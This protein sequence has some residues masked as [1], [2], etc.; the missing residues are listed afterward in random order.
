V[1]KDKDRKWL[2][3]TAARALGEIGPDAK[4]AVPDLINTVKNCDIEDEKLVSFARVN[5]VWALGEIAT[6][7]ALACVR[8]VVDDPDHLVRSNA[9]LI[10]K[11]IDKGK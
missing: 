2:R 5:A 8:E 6:K 7:E 1:L 10:V 3:G 11:R 9:R 4:D